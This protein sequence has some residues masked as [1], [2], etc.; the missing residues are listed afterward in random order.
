MNYLNNY[1]ND[2]IL[3]EP[4]VKYFIGGTL[5]ECSSFKKTYVNVIF[6]IAMA[7]LFL[8]IISVF[9]IYKYKGKLTL[10]EQKIKN[11]QKQEYILSKLQQLNM[12][13]KQQEKQEMNKSM[14]T[15]L[16]HWDY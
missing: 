11:N 6:N 13:K 2:P 9:L 1:T 7:V 12:H 16:P 15:D 5:K 14:I 8:T 10:N 4:G 3:I